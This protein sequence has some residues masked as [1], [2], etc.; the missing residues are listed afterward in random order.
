VDP[1]LA[2]RSRRP[3]H[4]LVV[5]WWREFHQATGTPATTTDGSPVLV[6]R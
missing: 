6:E 4:D 3:H 1:G 2:D 5:A